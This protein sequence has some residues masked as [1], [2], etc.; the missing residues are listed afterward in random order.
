MV[1]VAW[2]GLPKEKFAGVVGCTIGLLRVEEFM[3][4][5]GIAALV[6]MDASG[7]TG[8]LEVPKLPKKFGMSDPV[9]AGGA[10]VMGLLK[11]GEFAK[12]LG[13]PE[14]ILGTSANVAFDCS[15]VAAVKEMLGGCRVFDG[16][17]GC[18]KNDGIAE[19]CAS[20]A[21]TTGA[22]DGEVVVGPPTVTVV[23]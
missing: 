3:K 11:A 15:G 20:D 2:T 19:S 6:V 8:L 18:A 17:G 4:K 7:A 13:T 16:V 1:G 22:R 9:V 21:A 23:D 14:A 10:T 5:L 12:K